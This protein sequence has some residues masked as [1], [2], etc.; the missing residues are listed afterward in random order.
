MSCV[1]KKPL[2]VTIGAMKSGTS[3]LHHYM[4]MH[5]ELHLSW[6]KETN[7]FMRPDPPFGGMRRYKLLLAGRGQVAGE[8][9]PNYTKSSIFPG[10]AA[11]M[12]AVIPDAKLI[13]ILRD[14]AARALSHYHHNCL[15]GREQRAI[16][17]AFATDIDNNYII[18]SRYYAQ[19]EEYLRFYTA[20][21]IQIL[22]FAELGQDPE[23]VMRRVFGFVGVDPSFTHPNFGKVY[24][25]SKRKRQPNALGR[26][27][28]DIPLLRQARYV[29][30]WVFE[31]PLE[32]PR[33]E[34]GLRARIE[35]WLR[36]DAGKM[37]AF[38]GLSFD[39]WTV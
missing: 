13:Y 8:T 1:S 35:G 2:F 9:S 18:T 4:R 6:V 20:E 38:S 21:R 24:H 27:I 26:L 15:H 34:D 3:S 25:D 39:S 11:R 22:D 37:R 5:P 30:P 17:E 16:E 32:R 12:H 14:P 31:R 28:N 33:I 19:L 36:E 7:H 10:V 29:L 23:G